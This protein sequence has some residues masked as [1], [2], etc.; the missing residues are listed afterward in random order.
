MSSPVAL[1]TTQSASVMS[2]EEIDAGTI[3]TCCNCTFHR[4]PH[5]KQKQ[6]GTTVWLLNGRTEASVTVVGKV[7]YTAIGD[8]TGPY[9]S[10]PD[11]RY[12]SSAVSIC[13]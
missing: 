1:N 13:C 6:K 2:H 9:F 5:Q 8:K 11:V 3:T 10:L 4:I 7:I 12:M